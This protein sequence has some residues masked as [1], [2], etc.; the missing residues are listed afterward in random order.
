MCPETAL[1][2]LLDTG[3]V[4]VRASPAV[5]AEAARTW[6]QHR[7]PPHQHHLHQVKRPEARTNLFHRPLQNCLARL[8]G[9]IT[10]PMVT[11]AQ[12]W[13]VGSRRASPVWECFAPR[14]RRKWG[15]DAHINCLHHCISNRRQQGAIFSS[16]RVAPGAHVWHVQSSI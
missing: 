14:T 13:L 15:T 11:S 16:P 6:L 8:C 10:T 12:G 1:R 7:M 3:E 2:R 4:P 9:N 5:R